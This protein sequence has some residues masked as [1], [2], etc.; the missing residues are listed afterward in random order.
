[1]RRP[2]RIERGG[3]PCP[4]PSEQRPGVRVDESSADD[5]PIEMG[6]LPGGSLGE[7]CIRKGLATEAQVQECLRIQH[8]EERAGRTAPRLGELLVRKG[9]L[10]PAQ[11]T[12]ALGQQQTHHRF[13]PLAP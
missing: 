1:M 12:E 4:A 9:Y 3:S 10:T 8:E 6:P 11:V 13:R 7:W 2:G 5:L